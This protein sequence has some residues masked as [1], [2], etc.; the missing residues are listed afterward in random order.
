MSVPDSEADEHSLCTGEIP[1]IYTYKV[2]ADNGH[3]YGS[4]A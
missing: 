1:S 3:V 2:Q 4:Q